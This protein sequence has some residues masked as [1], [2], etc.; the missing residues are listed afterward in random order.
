MG[1]VRKLIEAGEK[2]CVGCGKPTTGMCWT[3]CGMS[4][5]GAPLCGDCVHIDQKYG[6]DH[7]P[8]AILRAMEGRG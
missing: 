7:K 3:D 2:P 6:W 8:R 4:L 5:C 1:D